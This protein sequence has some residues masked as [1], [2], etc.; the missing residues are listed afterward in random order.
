MTADTLTFGIPQ[1]D[2]ILAP[3]PSQSKILLLHDPGVEADVFAIQAAH[4]RLRQGDTVVYLVTNRTPERVRTVLRAHFGDADHEGELVFVDAYTPLVGVGG[5]EAYAVADPKDPE[6]L[7]R[8]LHQAAQDHPGATLVI[9][10]LS[11]LVDHAGTERFLDTLG[12]F[13]DALA[14]YAMTVALFTQW[15]YEGSID[16]L[17]DLFDAHV[18]L[19]G[20]EERVRF[21]QYFAVPHCAWRDDHDDRPRLYKVVHPGGVFVYIPKVVVTGPHNAGKSSFVQSISDEARSV[22]RLG[23]TVALDHGHVVIDGLSVDVFG[24]P[25]QARFDPIIKTVAGQALGV[26]LL[27]DAS[28]PET[29]PRAEDMM[30]LTWKL[31]IPIIVAANKQDRPGALSPAEVKQKL[32]APPYV[33]V[34]GCIGE[35]RASARNVL[36]RLLDQIMQGG[37][38][39][40]PDSDVA[41]GTGA[42]TVAEEKRSWSER[43][44]ETTGGGRE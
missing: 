9:D 27:V 8:T 18:R 38:H 3:I 17:F 6:D 25:G 41:P 4:A 12:T 1:L 16:A 5:S 19:R 31:G 33:Q 42:A 15:P 14:D 34:V 44:K 23:T 13:T 43:L 32:A 26:L 29:F 22:D 20:V 36:H 35:E 21:S 10:D 37:V 11:T 24:T 28:K 39:R 40:R 7:A 30:Q 2:K